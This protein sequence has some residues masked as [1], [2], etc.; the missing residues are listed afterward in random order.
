[1]PSVVSETAVQNKPAPTN[2][3]KEA[4][5]PEKN[6]F[7]KFESQKMPPPKITEL[8]RTLTDS[9]K[10]YLNSSPILNKLLVRLLDAASV[11]NKKQHHQA[12]NSPT[13]A[14][15]TTSQTSQIPS[16]LPPATNSSTATQTEMPQI[17]SIV[18]EAPIN[19]KYYIPVS[20]QRLKMLEQHKI[21]AG[22]IKNHFTENNIMV[23]LLAA[24]T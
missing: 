4:L 5:S 19:L 24:C 1:M 15:G 22:R 16:A 20:K 21:F 3:S 6:I 14:S 12:P 7:G 9:D 2:T 17:R 13:N 18:S 8:L 10:N 23:H 11:A